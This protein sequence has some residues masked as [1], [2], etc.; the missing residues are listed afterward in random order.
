MQC[1]V[2]LLGGFGVTVR[3]REIPAGAW[4]HRRALELVKILALARNHR[5]AA[6]Q[7]IDLLWP[8]LPLQAGGANLRKAAHFARTVLGSA[9]AVRLSDGVVALFPG[10]DLEVDAET[11]ERAV[12]AATR[13]QDDAAWRAALGLYGGDLLPDDRY[14]EWAAGPR[15]RLRLKYLEGLRRLGMWERLAEEEP[16]DEEAHRGLMRMWLDRGN[17]HAAVRAFD[18]L[19]DLLLRELG[20]RPS[21]ETIALWNE[22][23]KAPPPLPVATTPLVGRNAEIERALGRWDEAQ[24]GRGGVVLISGEAGIGKTRLC[25][26][27]ARVARADGA[28]VVVGA[29]QVEEASSPFAAILTTLDAAFAEHPALAGALGQD[30]RGRVAVPTGE[31]ARLSWLEAAMPGVERQRMFSSVARTVTTAA[32]EHGLM[33]VLEDVH[34]ADD[35]SLQLLTYLG[36]IAPYHRVLLVLSHRSEPLVPELAVLRSTL[37]RNPRCTDLRLGRLAPDAVVDL[38]AAA[39]AGH[40]SKATVESIWRLG[41]GNPFYC[42]ELAVA[43]DADGNLRIP[44]RLY[45]VVT[46]RLDRLGQPVREALQRVAVTED[47]FTADEFIAVVGVED[48]TAFEYLDEAILAG[49]IDEHGTGYRFR[50]ALLRR[51]LERSLPR[52]RRR[53]IHAEMAERL[54]AT[55]SDPAR[56]AYH[57]VEAGQ[58]GATAPWLEKAALQAAALGAYA[59]ALR[60]ATDA[61]AHVAAPEDVA[62]LLAL[63]ADLLYVTGDPAAVTAYDIALAKAPAETRPR[64]S[65]MKARALLATG[66]IEGAGRTADHAEP[67]TAEDRIAAAVVRGLVT[68]AGGAVDVAE[69]AAWAARDLAM[70]SGHTA[71]LGE[72][73]ELLGLVAHSRGLW[74]E[75]VRYE[76]NDTARRPEAVASSVFDAHLCLAEYLLYG[77]QPY[78]QVIEFA[79]ELRTTAVRSGAGRGEAFATCLLGEAE[80]LSG[81]LDEAQYHLERAARL[82]EAVAASAGQALS[83]QRLGEAAL[84]VGDAQRATTLLEEAERVSQGSTLERHLLGKVYG[85]MVLAQRDPRRAIT[86]V[87]RAE[88]RMSDQPLCEPCAMGFFVAAAMATARV[89]DLVRAHGYLARAERVSAHWP[90]GGWHAAALEA[91]AAVAAAEGDADAATRLLEQAAATFDQAGQRLDA[92]RCRLAAAA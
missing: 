59:D 48:A 85:T 80:L 15:E 57:L 28:V 53:R 32:S 54:G 6:D 26:E 43:T 33:L 46:A 84:A 89:N 86:V 16:L 66:D 81:R 65:L 20:V 76:L 82:H 55:G 67:V 75:R 44:D 17:R 14:D 3:G 78:D 35:G 71:G 50:H 47:R 9:D 52:H 74:R 21:P 40:A 90:G 38:V 25:E 37:L 18:R 62:R 1:T 83:L 72:A 41:E 10:G 34:H 68:W 91:R 79:S 4:R 27:L 2:A 22:I 7:V 11:F 39:S 5:L 31:P 45:E 36:R 30:A 88:A 92:E 12:D 63:R 77:Q 23:K 87:D 56:V 64:L 19:Q 42:E 73:T 51:A 24:A 58:A 60:L 13:T 8:D 69:D 29:A 49:V 70:A 61:S